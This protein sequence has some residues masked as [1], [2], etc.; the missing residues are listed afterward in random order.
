M[1][2][3]SDAV[4]MLVAANMTVFVTFRAPVFNQLMKAAKRD[5]QKPTT[6]D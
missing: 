6:T 4:R 1:R 2:L 3:A 5:A